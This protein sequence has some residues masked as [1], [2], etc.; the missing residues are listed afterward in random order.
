MVQSII[1]ETADDVTG[2]CANET[3]EGLLWFALYT[4][5]RS[6]K[7]VQERLKKNGWVVY[8][9][10]L[11]SVRQWSDRKKKVQVP[12]IP[13]IVFVFTESRLLSTVLMC[14]GVSSVIRYLGMPA[15][16]REHEINNLRIL[17][18][19]PDLVHFLN[20]DVVLEKGVPVRVVRGPFMGVIGS[21]VRM[22][23]RHSLVVEI[24]ALNSRLQLT[25]PVSFVETTHEAVGL[26]ADV[27]MA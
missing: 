5:P 6:E 15:P 8:L 13:G 24:G 27:A 1:V 14:E 17:L 25:L 22:Q 16:V 7:K 10:L 3:K 4:K 26:A 11:T 23:G 18:R 12:L 19:E 9:P 20:N 2:V 21:C